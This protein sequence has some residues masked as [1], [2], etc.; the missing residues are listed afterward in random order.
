MRLVNGGMLRFV[1]LAGSESREVALSHESD[2]RMKEM[3]EINS[4]LG[5]LKGKQAEQLFCFVCFS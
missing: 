5:D 3:K 4:S 2:E 1:D